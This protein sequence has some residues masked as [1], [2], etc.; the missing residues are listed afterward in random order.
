MSTLATQ[1]QALLA[2]LFAWPPQEAAL[3]L[4]AYAG[5]VGSAPQRGLQV[6]QANGHML[7]QRAL[8]ATYPVL[9]QMLGDDS[10][11]DLARAFWHA[12]P[13]LRGDI[14]QW[15]CELADFLRQSEQLQNEPFLP[16]VARAEWALHRC[17]TAPDR[18]AD[19]ASFALLI[20]EDPQTL[21]LQL[22]P[23]V[24]T[25]ASQ[26]PLASVLLAHLERSPSFDEVAADLQAQ[27][28]Q[29][30]VIWRAGL[31]PKLRQV[32]A[33]EPGLL[34][35]LKAGMA[36]E[37]ALD[38]APDIDFSQWFALAVQTGLVLGAR[39][40]PTAPVKEP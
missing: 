8:H 29:A 19:L 35:S 23:G 3:R 28:A 22:A 1:Q 40:I 26:W 24:T 21:A 30:V 37:P 14:A 6:Y 33:G 32:L 20:T 7:A 12:H 36:L 4:N 31:Q 2:A 27:R 34:Q 38:A 39:R 25:L 9:A 15:G 11:A 5:G 10:F 17:A 13:P 18:E 16:D